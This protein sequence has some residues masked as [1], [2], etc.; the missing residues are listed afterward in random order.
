MSMRVDRNG[1]VVVRVPLTVSEEAVNAFIAKHQAWIDKQVARRA[2]HPHFH[3]GDTVELLG[4]VV[5]VASGTRAKL[6]GETLFLPQN[7]REEALVSL[8]RRI[9]RE[10]MKR[11]LDEMCRIGGFTYTALSV[12]SARG[13]WG[14][15]S[16]K[17]GISFSFRTAFLPDALVEYLAVHELCHTR[18][19]NHSTKF[20]SEVRRILPDYAARRAALKRYHWAMDCL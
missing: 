3:D 6:V 16:S 11:Y 15:C 5:T 17:K 14:S 13:R 12:T 19:M 20:W 18:Q 4:R 1:K 8:L 7:G 9:T 10:R 2:D